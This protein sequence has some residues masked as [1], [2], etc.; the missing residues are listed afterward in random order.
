MR[1]RGED[2]QYKGPWAG[3]KPGS[4]RKGL[5]L[6]GTLP[7]EPLGA[8]IHCLQEPVNSGSPLPITMSWPHGRKV[9]QFL[10][11]CLK[12]NMK[13]IHISMAKAP[14]IAF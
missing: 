3:I 8:P 10:H 6:N 12:I 11:L 1:E 14:G 4:L 9:M 5:S 2:I 13:N 7:G